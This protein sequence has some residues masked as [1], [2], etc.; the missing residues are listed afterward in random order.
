MAKKHLHLLSLLRFHK[1]YRR[2]EHSGSYRLAKWEFYRKH[3]TIGGALSVLSKRDQK[4]T[5]LVTAIQVFVGIFDLLGIFFVGILGALSVS[6]IQNQ[7][8]GNQI[9]GI[10]EILNIASFTFQTQIMILSF[11]AIGLL[12]GRTFI[13]IIFTRRILLFF[14]SRA[15]V[16]STELVHKVLLRPDIMTQSQSSQ[17]ILYSLTRGV[18]LLLMQVLATFVVLIGDVSLLAI[19]TIGLVAV[20]PQ[21]ALGTTLV[22]S[23]IGYLLHRFMNVRAKYLGGLNSELNIKS[24]EKIVEVLSSYREAIVR[25]RRNYYAEEIGKIRF[26]LAKSTAELNFMPYVS[27]YVIESVVIIGT[28]MIGGVLFLLNDVNKAVA[29]LAVFLAAGSRIA[30]S[31][32]RVQQ[33]L[34]QIRGNL[35]A[36]A[37]TLEMIKK[38]KDTKV[39]ETVSQ[40]LAVDHEGFLPSLTVEKVTFTY[41]NCDNPTISKIS[42]EIPPGSFVAIV[43]KSGSGKSTLVDLI[44]GILQ[45]NSGSVLISGTTPLEAFEKWP[46]AVSYV[47]QDIAISNSTIR[48]NI[49]LGY[50]LEKM[51][52]GLINSAIDLAELGLFISQERKGLDTEVGERGAMLSGGQ[53]QRLG[54]ARALFTSPKLLVLDEATSALDGDSESK[55]SESLSALKGAVTII[56]VAHRLSTVRNADLVV[57]MDE[58][59]IKEMGTFEELRNK[60]SDFDH[61]AKLMGL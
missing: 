5:L 56:M 28:L 25:N 57:Y 47:P 15:A 26:A 51:N 52:D 14:S 60:L 41:P 35:G 53:R 59:K 39:P 36:C 18:E 20:D 34:V 3:S 48:D 21:I 37:P 27:K 45:P 55:I 4:K 2:C 11:L 24:N 12:V 30:P 8:P 19:I 29:T 6:G 22:F 46:G 50:P 33:N 23:I 16:I 32:L 17:Q 49:S 38:L 1:L 42:L 61:Q 44:L 10:L 9:A 13:S 54:I 40:D 7:G 31:V 43:G 58:G